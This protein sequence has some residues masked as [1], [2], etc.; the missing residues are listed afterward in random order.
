MREILSPG[1]KLPRE[2]ALPAA[3][4]S[5]TC[6]VTGASSGIGADIA[7]ELADRGHGVTLTARREDRL[8]ALAEELADKGVRAEA[9]A[10]DVTDPD[11]RAKLIAAI[12]ERGLDVEVLVNNAGYGSGGLFQ[13][14][15]GESEVR[16]VR[17]NC[18]AIIA[19]CA[20]Y[21]PQMVERGR[22]AVLNVGSTAGFQ[23][24]PR[25]ATYSGTKAF[26]NTFSE[27]LSADLAGTGVSVTC[28][29]PGPVETEFGEIAG[30]QEE[31]LASP[32]WTRKTPRETAAAAV[33]GVEKG[34]RVVTPGVAA[35]VGAISGH[36]TPRSILLPALRRF[37]PVGK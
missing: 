14:L 12:A 7:R 36:Y 20:E 3:S 25:Q 34:R 9:I 29:C 8:Q 37:Y 17:T 5:S 6:L 33:R 27:A 10:G 16:M 11:S 22:G 24:L 21:V 19:F 2:V 4:P 32:S 26:V 28:L 23:P 13:Q 35:T 30:L 18:E 15:D 31:L 1:Y